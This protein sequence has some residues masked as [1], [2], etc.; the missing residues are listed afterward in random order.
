MTE[1]KIRRYGAYIDLIP[2]RNTLI[3]G[4][5]HEKNI[6]VRDGELEMIDMGD[7]SQGHRSWR[8]RLPMLNRS[9]RTLSCSTGRCSPL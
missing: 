4:D 5:F 8:K 9:N 2:K 1:E 3:H 7:I 6:L